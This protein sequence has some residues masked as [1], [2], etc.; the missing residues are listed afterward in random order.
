ML[1]D[2]AASGPTEGDASEA[3]MSLS[4]AISAAFGPE[5]GAVADA[6][7]E[8]VTPPADIDDELTNPNVAN[9]REGAKGKNAGDDRDGENATDG[10]TNATDKKAKAATDKTASNA[11]ASEPPKHWDAD[12]RAAFAKLPPDGQA[13][14]LKLAK[15]LEG[16]FTRKSQELSDKA[17][18]ADQ[19]S[20]LFDADTRT[21]L[22]RAGTSEAGAIK[23]LLD[24]QRFASRD[25]VGYVRWAM[26][27][28][29][30]TPETLFDAPQT[31]AD[32]KGQAAPNAQPGPAKQPSETASVEDLLSDPA[33]KQLR[34]DFEKAQQ[35]IA[36]QQQLL[37]EVVG[38]MTARERAEH[39]Y[40]T[41]QRASH[42]DQLQS[43]IQSFRTK[44]DD[45][46][47]LAYPHFDKVIRQMGA[48]MDT[49]PELSQM[50][51][52][53]EKMQLAYEQAVHARPDL[54]QES[55][56]REVARRVQAAEKKARDER[57]KRAAS[58]PKPASGA[59]TQK[60]KA[61]TLDDAIGAA[62]GKAGF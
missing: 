30:V 3:K 17:R 25:P 1:P 13:T 7:Q 34:T 46:G 8:E 56:E 37:Q 33:V 43:T 59:P 11:K 38:R 15:N 22:K 18:F 48:L 31:Q 50:P 12:T 6:G 32:G 62:F 4:D 49:D 5:E 14:M 60:V 10:E 9:L 45:S 52:G 51:D 54:R 57:A 40:V 19:V 35:T 47:Q 28:L 36:Q 27:N 58:G 2:Q 61:N 20:G 53:P 44:I 55:I 26:Q 16:G 39:E 21:Q 41:N 29:G 23:Y 24:T 42:R